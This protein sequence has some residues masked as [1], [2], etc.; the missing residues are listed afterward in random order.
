[1]FFL[2]PNKEALI[3]I[4]DSSSHLNTIKTDINMEHI[5]SAIIQPIV[6]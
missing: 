5:G 3:S 1:M 2:K 6:K 4:N